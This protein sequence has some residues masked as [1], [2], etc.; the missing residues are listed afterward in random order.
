MKLRHANGDIE[1][2]GATPRQK[3]IPV[4]HDTDVESGDDETVKQYRT[5]VALQKKKTAP[6]QDIEIGLEGEDSQ[7][8]KRSLNLKV[9]EKKQNKG[10]RPVPD[11]ATQVR[12]NAWLLITKNLLMNFQI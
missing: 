10:Q 5:P 3:D 1:D 6:V 12:Q 11:R 8:E 2:N 7:V 4:E 9:T